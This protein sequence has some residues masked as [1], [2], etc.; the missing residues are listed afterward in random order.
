[1]SALVKLQGELIDDIEL[2][3]KS[4]KDSV[5]AAEDDIIQSKKN[6]QSARKV[7]IYY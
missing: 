5:I 2:N 4:A 3:I 7:K 1:M 6:M